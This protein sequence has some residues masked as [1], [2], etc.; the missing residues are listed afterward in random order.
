MMSVW[1]D[2]DARLVQHREELAQTNAALAE[3]RGGALRVDDF[4][5][6]WCSWRPTR[7]N[8][9]T[10]RISARSAPELLERLRELIAGWPRKRARRAE[11]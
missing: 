3:F 10:R 6:W 1:D 8:R 4:G 7:G 9:V 2:I 11:S 5:R